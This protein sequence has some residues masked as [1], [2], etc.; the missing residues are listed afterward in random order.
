[1]TRREGEDNEIATPMD[2]VGV[3]AASMPLLFAVYLSAVP[4]YGLRVGML[5]GF[6]LLVDAALAA[7]AIGRRDEAP[8]AIGAVA[9]LLVF[10]V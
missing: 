9:T 6:L 7:V 8:H 3:A 10:A 5:F 1:V 4:A 2:G